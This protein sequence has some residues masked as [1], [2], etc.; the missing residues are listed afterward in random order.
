MYN[1]ENASMTKAS[2]LQQSQQSYNI[3]HNYRL[4][5]KTYNFEVIYLFIVLFLFLLNDYILLHNLLS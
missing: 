4:P 5:I 1:K 3:V 2:Q